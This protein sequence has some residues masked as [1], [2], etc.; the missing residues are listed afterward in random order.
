MPWPA[1][2]KRVAE[3]LASL[4]CAGSQIS[5]LGAARLV[6]MQ[7]KGPD[8]KPFD[9]VV[10]PDVAAAPD[11]ATLRDAILKLIPGAG[12]A[13]PKRG[14]PGKPRAVEVAAAVEA[15]VPPSAPTAPPEPDPAGARLAASLGSLGYRD[16]ELELLPGGGAYRV[17]ATDA[18]GRRLRFACDAETLQLLGEGELRELIR[19]LVGRAAPR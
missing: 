4:G 1:Q 5:R 13:P 2:L 12:A 3:V 10:L 19:D 9:V 14:K 11:P 15:P 16:T 17:E 6:R 18:G 7:G 8:R